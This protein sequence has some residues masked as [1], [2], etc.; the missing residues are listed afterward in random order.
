MLI[1]IIIIN[2][3]KS[4][5]LDDPTLLASASLH[6][7]NAWGKVLLLLLRLLLPL[8]LLLPLILLP[9]LLLL[10]LLLLLPLP[11]PMILIITI[12]IQVIVIKG[13]ERLTT[14]GFLRR[15]LFI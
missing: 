12:T 13:R 9:L 6:V 1:N 10:L 11:L 7:I 8:L 3:D 5:P 15:L 4:K 2:N 14:R